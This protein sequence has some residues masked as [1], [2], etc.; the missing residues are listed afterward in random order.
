MTSCKDEEHAPSLSHA[1]RDDATTKNML[2]LSH[3]LD[4]TMRIPTWIK[5][6]QL[7]LLHADNLSSPS[8]GFSDTNLEDPLL[9]KTPKPLKGLAAENSLDKLSFSNL[10][11]VNGK[12]DLHVDSPV[13]KL[14]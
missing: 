7:A 1:G 3:A 6:T 13:L 2:H 12:N 14:F 9:A 8:R 4:A 10:C 5:R 11:Q